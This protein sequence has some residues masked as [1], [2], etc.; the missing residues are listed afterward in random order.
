M[1]DRRT[2]LLAALVLLI[3]V[4]AVIALQDGKP[5]GPA[6][7]T[8]DWGGSEG[9][10][11]CRYDP[12]TRTV[13]AVLVVDGRTDRRRHLTL[14][15]TAYADE[16]TSVP[17]GSSTRTLRTPRGTVHRRLTFTIPVTAPP[18]VGEDDETACAR[19]VAG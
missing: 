7:L 11:S 10:P 4:A 12:G 1:R 5:A 14:T 6:R 15:V 18:H 8:V 3:V 19:T 2:A 9:H 13:R 17:V 16:N